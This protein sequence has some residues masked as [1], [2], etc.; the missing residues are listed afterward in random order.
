MRTAEG[1]TIVGGQIIRYI[2]AYAVFLLVTGELGIL[3]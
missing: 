3:G 1:S 2:A